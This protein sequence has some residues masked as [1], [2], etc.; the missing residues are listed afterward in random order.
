MKIKRK[1]ELR[2]EVYT[3]SLNDIMFFL[4]LF[5]LI[6]STLVNPSVIQLML[7]K[8]SANIQKVSKQTINV[9]VTADLH[10]YLNDKP[11]QLEQIEPEIQR[12][13]YNTE[14]ATVILHAERSITLQDLVALLDIGQKLHVKMI[15][16]T[17]KE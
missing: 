7:P 17:Q 10:Y 9:T 2:P 13:V 3:A 8:S 11:I 5:F 1:R 6:V 15:L 4:L 16:A 14:E 12:L